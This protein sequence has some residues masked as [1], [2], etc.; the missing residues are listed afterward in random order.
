VCALQAIRIRFKKQGRA[1]YISHL[2]LN[3]CMARAI[4]RTNLPL[5]YT[6]GFNPHPYITFALP[7]SIFYESEC[8]VMDA[9]LEE[10]IPLEEVKQKLSAQMPE[11]I[12]IYDVC[13]PVLK[14][15]DIACA[16]Y[17]ISLEFENRS[18]A[19]LHGVIEKLKALDNLT[20]QKTTKH[21][22]REIDIKPF[23]MSSDIKIENGLMAI[24]SI[25]PATAQGTLNPS[26]FEGAL[27]KFAD[28]R[29]DFAR[30]KRTAVYDNEMQPFI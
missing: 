2:D 7:L 12:E 5:W 9:R 1:K 20:I 10:D 26:C 4:K 19:D 6:Q 18:A 24:E 3:R 27:L 25:L 8:E 17:E 15:V 16:R 21:G 23:L 22:S 14:P 11:G 28:I 13:E 29:P 30:V